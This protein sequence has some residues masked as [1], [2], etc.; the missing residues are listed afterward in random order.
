MARTRSAAPRATPPTGHPDL[1]A[2]YFLPEGDAVYPAHFGPG[3][4]RVALL[5]WQGRLTYRPT[6][7]STRQA[8]AT[9]ARSYAATCWYADERDRLARLSWEEQPEHDDDG[10]PM[11]EAA[12]AAWRH[13]EEAWRADHLD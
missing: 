6:T 8:C 4:H 11:N 3:E 5:T 10:H 2:G 12:G 13:D 1:S 9:A 7:Y